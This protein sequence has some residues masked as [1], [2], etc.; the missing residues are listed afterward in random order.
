MTMLP[1]VSSL[2][3]LRRMPPGAAE[4]RWF[5]GFADPVFSPNSIEIA[6]AIGNEAGSGRPA[7]PGVADVPVRLRGL[8]KVET[9]E[10]QTKRG[11]FGSAAAAGYPRG[12]Q[13]DRRGPRRRSQP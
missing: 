10:K 11:P 13:S 1:T 2:G 12:G 3:T 7:A 6:S 5:A 4:R 8:T 9:I